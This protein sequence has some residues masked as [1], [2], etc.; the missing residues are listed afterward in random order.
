[1]DEAEPRKVE[2]LRRTEPLIELYRGA[3]L[4]ILE[5]QRNRALTRKEIA[6]FSIER[7]L[8]PSPA[9]LPVLQLALRHLVETGDVVRVVTGYYRMEWRSPSSAKDGGT[10]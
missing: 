4:A 8:V 5:S 9:N 3:A 6:R 7:N 2:L 1:M 10:L